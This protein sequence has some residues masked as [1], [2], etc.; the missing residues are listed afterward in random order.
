MFIFSLQKN[1][2]CQIF[3]FKNFFFIFLEKTL[4]P[5]NLNILYIINMY[6]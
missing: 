5:I 4:I 6:N 1:R 2:C 3:I